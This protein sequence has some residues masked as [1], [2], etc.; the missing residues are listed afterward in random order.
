MGIHAKA[1]EF[2]G[3]PVVEYQPATGLVLPV[4][5]RREFRP[6]DGSDGFWAIALDRERVVV[7][8]G[9]VGAA[10]KTQTRTF[11]STVAAQDR[12][13]ELVAE[14]V[15]AGWRPPSFHREFRL[16]R[17]TTP[18]F[19]TVT[20]SGRQR[21]VVSGKAGTQG[22]VS[23]RVFK[24][25][26]SALADCERL[27]AR[28][29]A[30]GYVEQK[31]AAQSLR[32]ALIAAIRAD[33]GDAASRNAF[34]DYLAEQGE[35]LPAAAYRVDADRWREGGWENFQSFLADPAAGLVQALVVGCCWGHNRRE[36]SA[37]VVKA[38]IAARDR[39]PNLCAL[40][41]GDIIRE[42]REISWIH[43]SDITGLFAA[44][45]KLEH[46]RS[47]GGIDL[48]LRPFR[49]E[50]LKSLVIEA[51]NLPREVVC[52]VGASDLPALEHLELWLGAEEY[53]ANTTPA[54][55]RGILQSKKLPSLRHLGLRNSEIVDDIPR[56]LA[57]APIMRRLRSLDLSLGT[58]SD[59]GAESLAEVLL[60]KRAIRR[61]E[62]LDIHH[63]YVSEMMLEPMLEPLGDLGIEVDAGDR[64]DPDEDYRYVAHSE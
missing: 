41:L 29:I 48:V 2:A 28:R 13:L 63:H 57:G 26:S 19:W 21:T 35:A 31:P 50:R 53:G 37:E 60:S 38:L 43:Q 52:A 59:Y 49:H 64:Q 39:L 10:G 42:Q 27:I 23:I 1:K 8:S 16:D 15:A 45:P 9:T 6:R 24:A 22:K 47:R 40:F 33:P 4:M 62:K 56:L 5:P 30:E 51:S 17:G 55:L 46:F 20:L 18:K 54:D 7:H 32:E 3:L 36:G 44:F 61:L 12:Y 25:E 11:A 34:L 14:K 58:L